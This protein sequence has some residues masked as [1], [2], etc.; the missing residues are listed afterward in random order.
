LAARNTVQQAAIREAL[1]DAGRPLAPAEIL[2]A[3]RS[4]APRLG[5]AT[6]YR[7]IQRL[8]EGRQ[9]SR[10]QVPGLPDRYQWTDIAHRHY[11]L[12]RHCQRLFDL[13]SCPGG[14]ERLAPR[15]F[16]AEDHDLLI[17]GLCPD[18]REAN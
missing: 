14:I 1:R 3:A 15:G 4:S 18:C 7:G 2:D 12:C 17:R 10:V 13:K 6:V 8:L 11:F 16:Q 9:I 5:L